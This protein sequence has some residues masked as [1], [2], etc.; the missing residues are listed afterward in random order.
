MPRSN[1]IFFLSLLIFITH[2]AVAF[3]NTEP[4]S[5]HATQ[6]SLFYITCESVGLPDGF[7]A[8]PNVF[9]TRNDSTTGGYPIEVLA[10]PEYFEKN[11][12]NSIA[13]QVKTPLT[14]GVY[15]LWLQPTGDEPGQPA[16]GPIPVTEQFM[17]EEPVIESV[18]L[19]E[20]GNGPKVT[21]VGRFFGAE[22]IKI[23]IGSKAFG[24]IRGSAFSGG[25]FRP[26]KIEQPYPFA[27]ARSQPG[28]S[29]MDP[30]IG[31]SELSFFFPY[32]PLEPGEYTIGL[33][34]PAG[35][36]AFASL[37]VG[38]S[39]EEMNV[40]MDVGPDPAAGA[41]I[42]ES[43]TEFKITSG[44]SIHITATPSPHYTFGGWTAQGNAAF[45]DA[46]ALKTRV[47]VYEEALI[48]ADFIANP[49]LTMRVSQAES[50]TTAPLPDQTAVVTPGEPVEISADSFSGWH[51]AG[52]TASENASL[53][54][55][56]ALTTDVTLTGD[57]EVTANFVE[58]G[59]SGVQFAG[60]VSATAD[61]GEEG[62]EPRSFIGLTW[63]PAICVDTPLED[64]QYL[65]YVGPSD[66]PRDLF[67][68]QNLAASITGALN[69]RIPV[70]AVPA[71]LYVQAVAVDRQGNAGI[72]RDPME[73]S[74]G[75]PTVYNGNLV[76]LM[77]LAGSHDYDEDKEI[78]TLKGDYWGK[79]KEG[80]IVL[81]TPPDRL[82]RVRKVR[83][84]YLDDNDDTVIW[85][86]DGALS[87]VIESGNIN[88]EISMDSSLKDSLSLVEDE[89]DSDD[90]LWGQRIGKERMAGNRVY[91]DPENRI[92]LIDRSPHGSE[93]PLGKDRSPELI[94]DIN[95]QV[96]LVLSEN[97]STNFRCSIPI[98]NNTLTH[99]YFSGR[100]KYNL[101]ARLSIDMTGNYNFEKE[102]IILEDLEVIPT[103][104]SEDDPIAQLINNLQH[105]LVMSIR[106]SGKSDL[107]IV[108]NFDLNLDVT[109]EIK[110]D[111]SNGWGYKIEGLD[112]EIVK[113]RVDADG[114][115]TGSLR[116]LMRNEVKYMAAHD[117]FASVSLINKV[118]LSASA[119]SN[120]LGEL[121]FNDLTI[122]NQPKLHL[123]AR[124]DAACDFIPS[125]EYVGP[126]G[127]LN[128]LF[129][130]PRLSE[131]PY[132]ANPTPAGSTAEPTND[133]WEF[134]PQHTQIWED[135]VTN[136][137]SR[138]K[139]KW[140]KEEG[141]EMVG[142]DA[143]RGPS[144]H[145]SK[146]KRYPAVEPNPYKLWILA[147]YWGIRI[148][149]PDLEQPTHTDIYYLRARPVCFNTPDFLIPEKWWKVTVTEN[150]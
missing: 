150:D 63:A 69:A 147:Q 100:I 17:V 16:D 105:K 91:R 15:T 87:D 54:N 126:W 138:A 4:L 86:E 131:T 119:N 46:G 77:R 61:T 99:C 78:V 42:P 120:I 22:G 129:S 8:K 93:N 142:T 112:K 130:L 50:G 60:L 82:I 59:V 140:Y 18:L 109:L 95:P 41:T 97:S 40:T 43:G 62:G 38:Q 104:P 70:P 149:K 58:N 107:K 133:E 66:V 25:V 21:L 67:Q 118:T 33:R 88:G 124:A 55:N 3:G 39:R 36:E 146:V 7:K 19:K 141:G 24:P 127:D 121:I 6:G 35:M 116:V 115:L 113:N 132:A 75:E 114:K 5:Y 37:R 68:E 111:A 74:V 45:E 57:A 49:T 137:I 96:K 13:C 10:S 26:C 65:I 23:W 73:I 9:L 134:I 27:D 103:K 108:E 71:V 125:Y 98:K 29:C 20:D 12:V 56:M 14:A 52:W 72:P 90:A 80:D 48:T 135:G 144:H 44:E 2:V 84:L 106:Y 32:A 110:W 143:I 64:I 139:W 79:V 28:T 51:F 136:P 92:L 83:L 47:T 148:P 81:V 102:G 76:N 122:W 145:F 128:K 30:R 53:S 1:R 117:L 94:I 11:S 123:S 89:E 31:L 101:H 34:N 85:L